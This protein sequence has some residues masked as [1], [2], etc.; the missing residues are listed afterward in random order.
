MNGD[1]PK[2]EIFKPFGEAFELMKKILFQPFD[3]KKWLVIGFTAWLASLSGGGGGFNYPYDHRQN[4]QKFNETISQIPQ[5]VLITGICVLIC[6]VLALVLVVAWLRARGGFM[7]TDCVAKNRGAV[8]APWR[9][10][11][12][13]G[14]SYFLFTLLVGFVLL[15]VAALLS[16]PFMVPIIADVTFRHTHAVYLISTI[17]AWAFVMILFLV[18]WSVLAS[19]MVPIMYVR[20]CRAFEAFR[21][22]ARLISEHPGEILLYWLFL[23]VLAV[24]SAIVAFVVTCAT[25]CITAIPY[26]GTVILLPVFVL[27]RSFS[28]LFIRQ[29]GADYDVW[30]RFIPPEFLPV[31]MP[32]PLPSASEPR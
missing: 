1:E 4:T 29:F 2:I 14:N 3:F 28:L 26:V 13:E 15:I 20:R 21:T 9:E 31:L 11:R 19:F 5:P 32:P 22:A 24:A 27:L 12:T 10:F 17:A 8:V 18:A 16:L 7:F 23:I 6:V 30:A 25:C